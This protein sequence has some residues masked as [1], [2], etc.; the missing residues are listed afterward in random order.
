MHMKPVRNSRSHSH[1]HRHKDVDTKRPRNKKGVWA[2]SYG[3]GQ[4]VSLF[5]QFSH[6]AISFDQPS[7]R[8]EVKSK[9]KQ[10][11]YY[12]QCTL[13]PNTATKQTKTNDKEMNS[14]LNMSVI[15]KSLYM[16]TVCPNKSIP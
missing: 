4:T 14:S 8:Q 15:S 7:Y 12:V 3:F 10:C 9:K 11:K 1:D 2:C 13:I 16:L 6:D 5:A